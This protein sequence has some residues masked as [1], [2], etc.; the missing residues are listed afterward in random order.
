[1]TDNTLDAAPELARPVNVWNECRINSRDGRIIV[2][3][4]GKR[5][6]EIAGATPASGRIALQSEGSA[7]QFRRIRL[8]NLTPTQKAPAA[9]DETLNPSKAVP[10]SECGSTS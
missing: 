8:R 9:A 6:G 1:M 7:V 10:V 4:N 5:A 3:I 2:E